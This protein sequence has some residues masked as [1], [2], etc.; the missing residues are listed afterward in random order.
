GDGG[1]GA[2]PQS[3]IDF[4]GLPIKRSL[5]MVV[6]V[7]TEFGLRQ[8]IRIIASGKLV[9]PADVAW[10]LCTGADVA[11]S[12]RGF[13]FSLGCIQAL[14]CNKNTCPTGITTHNK[15]LQEG[16]VLSDKSERVAHYAKNLLKELEIISHSVGVSKPTDLNR[17]HIHIINEEGLP[18]AMEETFPLPTVREEYR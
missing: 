2:A 15:D 17:S 9:N 5:P 6:D 8:R 18:E 3:L 11:V 13:M 4:M 16:L 10:A 12:A 14:Q 7:L 1:T